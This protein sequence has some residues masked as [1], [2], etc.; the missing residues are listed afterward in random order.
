MD[1]CEDRE[2]GVPPSKTTLCGED[3]S[4]SKGQRIHQRLRPEPEPDPCCVSFKSDRSKGDIINFKSPGSPPSERIQKSFTQE[5]SEPSSVSLKSAVSM[6]HPITFKSPGAP[7]SE[8]VDQQSSEVPSGPS[9][10][11]HQT[12]LDSIFM[13]LEEFI[14]TFVKNELKKIQKVLSPNYPECSESQREDDEVLEGEDEE[15]RS[16]SRE[17]VMKITLNFLRRMKQEELADHL[18]SNKLSP[19]QWSALGFT[20]VSPGKDLDEFDLKKFSASEE[21]LLRLLPVVKASSK[22]LLSVCNLSE[23]SCEALSSVLSSQSSSLRELDL[24]DNNL[25]DSGVKLLSGGL[26]SPN[27]NLETLSLSGCL[28]SKKGCASLAS[29]LTSNPSHLK[30]LDLS[31]NHPRDSG[32]K[33]LSAGLKDPYWRLEALSGVS[34]RDFSRWRTTE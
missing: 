12:Q 33:L 28:V 20:L 24:S 32:V 1:Q 17:A 7:K 14:V 22:A 21:T 5:E 16:S 6:D 13:L 34:R 25:Q 4:Q 8:G 9:A 29:A 31:Y 19:A 27:C 15:Q 2:D 30:E 3:E 26:K 18:Q 23:R 10:Q 11:Q